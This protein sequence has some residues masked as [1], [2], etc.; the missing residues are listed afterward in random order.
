MI[1]ARKHASKKIGSEGAPWILSGIRVAGFFWYVSPTGVLLLG[2]NA[3]VSNKSAFPGMFWA[4]AN[5]A[6]LGVGAFLKIETKQDN[7]TR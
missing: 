1:F 4:T 5:C 7:T 3:A 2:S 6:Q